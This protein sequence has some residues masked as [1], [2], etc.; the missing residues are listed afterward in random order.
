[1]FRYI[2]N[3]TTGATLIDYGIYKRGIG[4][5]LYPVKQGFTV[6]YK[7]M[8]SYN[9]ACVKY[10]RRM[11]VQRDSEANYYTTNKTRFD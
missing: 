7:G 2:K 4:S 3:D 1:M 11:I 9:H 5:V 6:L 8:P 10:Q